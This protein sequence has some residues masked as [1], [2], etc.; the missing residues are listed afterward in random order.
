MKTRIKSKEREHGINK[1]IITKLINLLL[2]NL[3]NDL[4][5]CQVLF[6]LRRKI[7]V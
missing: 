4:K 2:A 6:Y 7:C 5:T 3:Y 1:K